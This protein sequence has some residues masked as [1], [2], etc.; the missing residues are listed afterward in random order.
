MHQHSHEWYDN[1]LSE[2]IVL[3]ILEVFDSW[4]RSIDKKATTCM[5]NTLGAFFVNTTKS[6]IQRQ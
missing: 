4:T 6:K 3:C 2:P 5:L 1:Y